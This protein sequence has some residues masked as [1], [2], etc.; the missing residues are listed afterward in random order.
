MNRTSRNNKNHGLDIREQNEAT[1]DCST[2]SG[3]TNTGQLTEMAEAP[4]TTTALRR[5]GQVLNAPPFFSPG[6][7]YVNYT[8]AGEPCTFDEAWPAPDATLWQTAMQSEM[9]SIYTNDT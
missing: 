5:S 9:D 8:D 3:S 6:L 2:T 4:E 1:T 7:N